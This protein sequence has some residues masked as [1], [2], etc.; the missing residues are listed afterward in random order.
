MALSLD[1]RR[2][3]VRRQIAGRGIGDLRV[4]AA[5]GN[6]PREAFV[7]DAAR[8]SSPTRT[9][10]CRSSEGQTIS[11]PYIVALMAEALRISARRAGARDRHRL[12][13]R[14]RRARAA[15]RREVFTIERHAG[16]RRPARERLDAA[17]LRQRRGATRRRHAGLA[18]ARAVR[19]HHRR[20]RRPARAREPARAARDRRP[21]GDAGRPEPRARSSSA[22][23]GPA[24]TS[25][26]REDLGDVRFVPLIGEQGW[27]DEARRRARRLPA[28]GRAQLGARRSSIRRARARAARPTSTTPSFDALFDRFG[29]ARVVLLGEATPRHLRVLPRARGITQRAHRASRLQLRRGRGGLAGRR[30]H[31]PLRPPRGPRAAELDR[32]SA[33][34]RPGCGATPRSQALRRLAARA[35]RRRPSRRD[36]RLPRARPLQHVDSIAAVLDYLDGSTPTAAAVARERYGCLTPWQH[37]PAAYGRA[38]LR[39]RYRDLRGRRGRACCGSCSRSG[40]NTQ[41]RRRARS[42]TPPR[43]RG[44]SPTPSATTGP[45]TTARPSRWNLRDRHMFDTLDASAR[46]TRPERQ[47]RRLGAQLAHRRRARDR[48]GRVRGELNIGQLCRR[49][50]RRRTPC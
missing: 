27:A 28:P 50:L 42:S 19:R 21:A 44:S 24:R 39:G 43:T 30:A 46:R 37:D 49:T 6:V 8:A 23:P 47:G 34:S 13:L 35:Q 11:Q 16:A 41:R 7:P 32:R 40:S 26:Q 29:D 12:G 18:R 3:M 25:S 1:P 5:M 2:R 9:R 33:A 20:R 36:A 38:A 17:R 4:L 14:R 31:R 45:C 10:R 22:S 15:S 48:H